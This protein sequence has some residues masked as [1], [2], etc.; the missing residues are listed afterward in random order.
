LV[1][2][3]GVS[4]INLSN[5][6]RDGPHGIALATI[7][8][9]GSA[10]AAEEAKPM[11]SEHF[12]QVTDTRPD[13]PQMTGL[14]DD[15]MELAQRTADPEQPYLTVALDYRPDGTQPNRRPSLRWLQERE[16]ELADT[17]G[18]RGSGFDALT[19]GMRQ[20]HEVLD[21][22]GDEPPQGVICVAQPAAGDF[23]AIPLAVPVENGITVGPR[24]MLSPLARVEGAYP[25]FALL[26]ADSKQAFLHSFALGIRE[27][28]VEM[29]NARTHLRPGA[30]GNKMIE[31]RALNAV[32]QQMENFTK[33]IAEETRRT[34][35]EDGVNRLIIAADDQLTATLR[36]HF[37]KELDAK[38]IGTVSADIRATPAEL[39][40]LALPVVEQAQ[41][42]A[43]E[44]V[45][46]RLTTAALSAGGLG[47]FGVEETIA[48]L[49]AGQVQTLVLADDFHAD[50]WVDDTL[51]MLGVGEPP[52]EHP[53]GGD[54]DTLRRIDLAD[55]MIRLALA[56]GGEV[57]F[58]TTRDSEVLEDPNQAEE[59]R[60]ERQGAPRTL[61]EHGGVG[62]IL[63]FRLDDTQTVPN[64]Q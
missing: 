2:A 60:G 10:I 4:G 15:L 42:A 56:M 37:P 52:K 57:A 35:D 64:L 55:E 14:H 29:E 58:I 28:A 43:E 48:A 59:T 18:P 63:R 31:R 33:A 51:E 54:A 40:A 38:V 49:Q 62:A 24:P 53:A 21:G 27:R 32:E 39:L 9:T 34:L 45:V 1:G 23:R 5:A 17:L 20:V 8:A 6:P 46:Q 44:D 61:Q 47:V 41:R 25:P 12:E 26:L 7:G 13:V 11:V 19:E 3:N 16:Q 36:D 22:F 50:G 30:V